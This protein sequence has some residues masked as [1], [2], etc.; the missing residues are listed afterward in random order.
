MPPNTVSRTKP[1][2][3]RSGS[4][5]QRRASAAATPANQ[6]PSS[7]R[8]ARLVRIAFIIGVGLGGAGAVLYL[9]LWA[10][11]PSGEIVPQTLG[12]APLAPGSSAPTARASPPVR[13]APG[14]PGGHVADLVVGGLLLLA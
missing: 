7:G 13:V 9:W 6:R 14:P 8:P 5:P 3:T 2:R 10:L 1:P 11:V 4:T 12:Q